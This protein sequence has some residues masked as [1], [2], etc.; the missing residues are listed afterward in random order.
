MQV[1]SCVRIAIHELRLAPHFFKHSY[2]SRLESIIASPDVPA[3]LVD[4]SVVN[5]LL[6]SRSG[7]S[8]IVWCISPSSMRTSYMT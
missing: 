3:M 1:I 8:M 5:Q 2:L 6:R 4:L 7:R